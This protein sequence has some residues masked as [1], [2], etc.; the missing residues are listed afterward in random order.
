MLIPLIFWEQNLWL[1]KIKHNHKFRKEN[2]F[3]GFEQ[4]NKKETE[5]VR[6][7]G[8]FLDG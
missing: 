5:G 4:R 6:E 8:Q 7:G 1:I 3:F 2:Q